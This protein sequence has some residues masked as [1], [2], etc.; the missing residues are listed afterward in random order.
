M[1]T[2]GALDGRVREPSLDPDVH[3]PLTVVEPPLEGR[4]IANL[5][6]AARDVLECRRLG[7]ASVSS[8][9]YSTYGASTSSGSRGSECDG[10]TVARRDDRCTVGPFRIV[11]FARPPYTR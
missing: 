2:T 3:R 4:D 11:G 9:D 1:A 5:Q 8:R 7:R 6:R 10:G